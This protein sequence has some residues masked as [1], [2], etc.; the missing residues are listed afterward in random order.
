MLP[1]HPCCH[2]CH[3]PLNECMTVPLPEPTRVLQAS[4]PYSSHHIRTGGSRQDGVPRSHKAGEPEDHTMSGIYR[5]A[6][7]SYSSRERR[8]SRCL[9]W[10]V[11]Y[12]RK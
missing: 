3:R 7:F 5:E 8:S 11:R 9:R 6:R 12:L 4:L 1:R 10:A 2:P